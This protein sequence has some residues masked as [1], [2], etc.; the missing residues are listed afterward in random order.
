MAN[1][2]FLEVEKLEERDALLEIHVNERVL[3]VFDAAVG[4]FTSIS[5]SGV[6]GATL[7]VYNSAGTSV[8]TVANAVLLTPTQ[9]R[10]RAIRFYDNPGAAL[11]ILVPSTYGPGAAGVADPLIVNACG[12]SFPTLTVK[13]QGANTGNAAG[14]PIPTGQTRRVRHDG[15]S[16]YPANGGVTTATGGLIVPRAHAY[17]NAAQAIPNMTETAL[18][19][20]SERYDTD[21][22]HDS[23]GSNARLTCKTAGDYRL[24]GQVRFTVSTVGVRYA[25]LRLNGVTTLFDSIVTLN[26]SAS[27]GVSTALNVTYT[28]PFVLNDYVELLAYQD[29]GGALNVLGCYLEMEKMG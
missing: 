8:G 14:V 23:A 19:M 26:A 28:Y 25:F 6:T 2:T 7:P 22:I 21:T 29:T 24:S 16:A 3:D 12:G 18:A 10:H 17:H 1:T 9:A 4:G 27:A 5:L 11:T 20:N 13:S 15:E